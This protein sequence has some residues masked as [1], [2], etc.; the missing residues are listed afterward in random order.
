MRKSG[1]APTPWLAQN[2]PALSAHLTGVKKG[3]ISALSPTPT[4]V[5]LGSLPRRL[6]AGS[7]A[8]AKSFVRRPLRGHTASMPGRPGGRK[9]QPGPQSRKEM[10]HTVL[11]G[12]SAPSAFPTS[13]RGL[14]GPEAPTSA[15]PTPPCCLWKLGPRPR[16]PLPRPLLRLQKRSRLL[17]PRWPQEAQAKM[18]ALLLIRESPELGLV[19]LSLPKTFRIAQWSPK[20]W[21]CP[22]KL[23]I[24]SFLSPES[25]LTSWNSPRLHITGCF[26]PV[27]STPWAPLYMLLPLFERLSPTPSP[28]KLLSLLYLFNFL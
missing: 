1:R 13:P 17:R 18:L 14:S 11:W 24:I 15:V 28:D 20:A 22:I 23:G 26:P 3:R 16:P 12:S 10:A 25:R 6:S 21:M 2:K 5:S 8:G 19:I 9:A 27:V 4:W 7:W